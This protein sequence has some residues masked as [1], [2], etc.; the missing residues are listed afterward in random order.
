MT[1]D[2]GV[3]SDT[4]GLL[5]EQVKGRLGACAMIIHAGDIGSP[6]VLTELREIGEVV[7]VRG[8]VD[9]G[10]WARELNLTEYLQ[11]DGAS[12]CVIHDIG[13]LDLDPAAAGINVVIHGHSHK[14]VIEHK[15]GI[16]YLNPGSAGP[17]RFHLPVSMAL[18]HVGADGIV[19]ELIQ[20]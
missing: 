8:N 9:H 2:I 10:R 4:H 15:D 12:I 5:R 1:G 20:L 18:L 14:P 11:I 19:P 16:L 13:T 3:I 6:F 17:S 7:A